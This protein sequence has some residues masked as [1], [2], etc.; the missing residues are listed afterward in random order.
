M[1][2]RSRSREGAADVVKKTPQPAKGKKNLKKSTKTVTVEKVIKKPNRSLRKGEKHCTWD[3]E[4]MAMAVHAITTKQMTLHAA[5]EHYRVPKSTLHDKVKGKYTK[6]AG[7]GARTALTDKD[8]AAIV[9]FAQELGANGYPL[10]SE[11]L[12]KKAKELAKAR[13]MP[14]DLANKCFT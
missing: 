9:R 7:P 8:E 13:G 5:A 10:S 1:Q 12:R 14:E 2:L 11:R 3:R 4:M 6:S